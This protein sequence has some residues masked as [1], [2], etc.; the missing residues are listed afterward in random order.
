LDIMHRFSKRLPWCAAILVSVV[1]PT[2]GQEDA[3]TTFRSDTRL[4]VLHASVVGKDGQLVTSLKPNAFHVFEGKVEQ[5]IKKVT[6]EDVPV[7]L[8]LVID[9]SGSMRGKRKKVEAAS[10]AMVKASNPQDEVT[11][12]N[13]NDDAY[14]DV[15]FTNDIKRLE[16]GAA[17]IDSK[18]GTA[19]RDAISATIDYMKSKAK[20]DKK[21]IVVVTDGDD[22]ASSP[23][24]TLERLVQKAH[25]GE[26][27]IL[28]YSIGL[29]NEESKRDANRCKNALRALADA[30]GGSATFPK[31]LADVE[32]ATLE[33]AREIR[34]QYIIEYNPVNQNFDG[35]FRNVK[36]VVNAA[37]RPTVRTRSG[38]YATPDKQANN[39]RR[40]QVSTR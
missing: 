13:F 29:L 27:N 21:V 26:S 36:V 40:A 35:A 3:G 17:R 16:E 39:T 22:N 12:V 7:S 24:M 19:M 15:L 8:G 10:L 14:Q 32:K 6:R 31:E 30:S 37:G 38:Y 18:G 1:L 9:N 11:I 2:R 33:V 28:I 25:Q 20:H 5:P 23:A 4:V 34:N